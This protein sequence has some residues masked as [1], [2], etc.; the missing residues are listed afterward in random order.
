MVLQHMVAG[1]NDDANACLVAKKDELAMMCT[2]HFNVRCKFGEV[3]WKHKFTV[4]VVFMTKERH[5][6]NVAE[7]WNLF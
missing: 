4:E 5:A 2:I 6:W 1:E 3:G 7:L